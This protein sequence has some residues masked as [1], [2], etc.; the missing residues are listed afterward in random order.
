MTD[1]QADEADDQE[2][3]NPQPHP[4]AWSYY[5]LRWAYTCAGCGANHRFGWHEN[6]DET[7][8]RIYCYTCTPRVTTERVW[9]QA[10]ADRLPQYLKGWSHLRRTP[11]GSTVTRI[12][13]E[14]EWCRT[15]GRVFPGG[16]F[17]DEHLAA[18]KAEQ[19][20]PV[21]KCAWCATEFTPARSDARFCSGRCR[22]AN[23]RAY[24]W[25]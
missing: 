2:A 18:V 21:F 8:E 5:V 16:L 11:V 15:L 24:R 9:T 7:G 17:H 12:H 25:V 14:W 20:V 10:D 3:T 23:H 19:P 22:V 13:P 1:D 6:C 4:G